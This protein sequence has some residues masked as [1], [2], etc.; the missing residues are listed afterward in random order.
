[1]EFRAINEKKKSRGNIWQRSKSL[2]LLIIITYKKK[3]K[4]KKTLKQKSQQPNI[5]E[6][7]AW[8]TSLGRIE[9]SVL[10]SAIV[11]KQPNFFFL[12]YSPCPSNP[13]SRLK[14]GEKYKDMHPKQIDRWVCFENK[15]PQKTD[16]PSPEALAIFSFVQTTHDRGTSCKNCFVPLQEREKGGKKKNGQNL[17]TSFL[18]LNDAWQADWYLS[19]ERLFI[20]Q[21]KLKKK[22][23]LLLLKRDK[24]RES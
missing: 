8:E 16:F 1:M 9:K 15:N 4:P 23:M 5:S 2:E 24:V 10:H 11:S 7:P 19:S 6:C 14:T 21:I 17:F 22:K 18:L 3:K 13:H 12:N 20:K